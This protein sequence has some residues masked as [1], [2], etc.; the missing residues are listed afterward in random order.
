M[1]D[2]GF[3]WPVY[4]SASRLRRLKGLGVPPIVSDI[5]PLAE[6]LEGTC[7]KLPP[8]QFEV[9]TLLAVLTHLADHGSVR[10]RLGE[11]GADWIRKHHDAARI[12]AQYLAAIRRA[13]AEPPPAC[14]PD[15]EAEHR[16]AYMVREVAAM[17]CR[18]GIR[19][20]DYDS[21]RSLA[22]AIVEHM[23]S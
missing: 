1:S 5:G 12:A 22:K 6:L 2:I 15:Y 14:A 7:A 20:G 23:P 10:H 16:L 13:V 8:D 19:E 3:G 11:N 18:M 17:A 4:V 21:L 9:A